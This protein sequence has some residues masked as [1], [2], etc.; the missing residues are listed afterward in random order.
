[1][2]DG[3]VIKGQHFQHDEIVGRVCRPVHESNAQDGPR[4]YIKCDSDCTF[5]AKEKQMGRDSQFDD[6]NLIPEKEFRAPKLVKDRGP[7]INTTRFPLENCTGTTQ[8]F[9]PRTINIV[10]L[11][12]PET[13]PGPFQGQGEAVDPQSETKEEHSYF[14]RDLTLLINKYSMENQSNTPDFILA[15]Y[16]RGC[17]NAFSFAVR[18][19]EQWYGRKTF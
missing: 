8:Q 19:R 14:E 18:H 2:N 10:P 5:C 1:M 15:E 4:P 3:T 6:N 16:L 12:S 9:P 17:L 13:Q 11:G 7:R